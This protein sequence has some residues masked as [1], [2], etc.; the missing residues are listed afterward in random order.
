MELAALKRM[1]AR[2]RVTRPASP[3]NQSVRPSAG[4][5][6]AGRRTQYAASSMR[7]SAAR[8]QRVLLS[9]SARWVRLKRQPEIVLADRPVHGSLRT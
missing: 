3:V 7:V 2:T 9:S 8:A 6:M 4:A 1:P 5:R